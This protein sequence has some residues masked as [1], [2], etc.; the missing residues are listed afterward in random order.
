V[1]P[2]ARCS[3]PPV[4]PPAGAMPAHPV[5]LPTANRHRSRRVR[6]HKKLPDVAA[7]VPVRGGCLGQEGTRWPAILLEGFAIMQ[8]LKITPSGSRVS[9]NPSLTVRPPCPASLVTYWPEPPQG[10]SN[11]GDDGFVHLPVLGRDGPQQLRR[12]GGRRRRASRTTRSATCSAS[13][14]PPR[15]SK[16]APEQNR[17]PLAGLRRLTRA[18]TGNTNGTDSPDYGALTWH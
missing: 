10:S 12:R 16:C 13:P 11:P 14:P 2:T 9:D 1:R 5:P 8:L 17:S 6:R 3:D 7:D 15:R 18:H 4:R